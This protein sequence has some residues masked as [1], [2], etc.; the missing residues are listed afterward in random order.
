MAA[1]GR[2]YP[3]AIVGSGA[4]GLAFARRLSERGRVAVIARTERKAKALRA[5]V[6]VG[7]SLFR[8]DAFGPA[9]PPLADCVI[10]LVKTYDT[11]G[12][13]RV[14]ARMKPR[15]VLSL[16]NGLVQGVAQGVTTAAAYRDGD[17]VVP[18]AVG[19][20]RVPPG[21]APL[22]ALLRRAGLPCRVDRR[23]AEARY[24]KLLA[25]V[26]I[27]PVTALYGVRNGE[28]LRP[29]Y[30]RLVERLAQEAAAVLRAEGLSLADEA[31]LA[32]VAAVARATAGNRSS[33]L[34]DV[35]A[36]RRTEIEQLNGALLRLAR[37]HRVFAPTHEAVYRAVRNFR[38][39]GGSLSG[40]GR[41]E[42]SATRR[43]L[44]SRQLGSPLRT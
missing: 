37:R 22:A 26:C 19:E 24:L 13:L 40:G 18:V 3:L 8:P 6:R 2:R 9:A 38:A 36:G 14:A 34:Q 43:A 20:T 1:S 30:R 4:L 39:P 35:L 7:R 17:A 23:I 12:A 27:N 42:R 44:E 10:V 33:M 25:N 28:V 29:P 41:S 11:A 15:K 5:G 31:A 21:F 32:R 16:Q